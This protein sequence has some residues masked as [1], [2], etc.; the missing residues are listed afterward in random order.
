MLLT[1]QNHV[2][3]RVVN[4]IFLFIPF[5]Q[6]F[7]IDCYYNE[8]DWNF[9]QKVYECQGSGVDID[10]SP[11]YVVNVT[12]Q[13][14]IGGNNSE[15]EAMR[16]MHKPKI[17]FIPNG[18]GKFFP[19]LKGLTFLNCNIKK[20]SK[21]H[22]AEFPEMMQVSYNFN[23]IEVIPGDLFIYTPKLQLV[24]F[25]S[26]NIKR[27][28]AGFFKPL[29]SL[30]YIWFEKNSCI[31]M[32]A[33]VSDFKTLKKQ[34]KKN[35]RRNGVDCKKLPRAFTRWNE[36]K[37]VDMCEVVQ[38]YRFKP[39]P[40][41]ELLKLEREKAEK[42]K[43]EEQDYMNLVLKV[44]EFPDQLYRFF[45][46]VYHVDFDHEDEDIKKAFAENIE[47]KIIDGIVSVSKKIQKLK[48]K[49]T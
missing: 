40:R 14:M 35:C 1:M 37:P 25:A 29:K 24:N 38:I 8:W 4:F 21:D 49:K 13:H 18:I 5:A 23:Q 19:N 27:I 45:E 20:I 44:C 12:G 9:K 39:K 26:N 28:G 17:T 7:V 33:K 15:V 42:T 2:T 48:K 10:I 46:S 31:D 41:H 11:G 43:K 36:T 32:N 22:L 6:T 47:K 3:R 16:F 34:I 30:E